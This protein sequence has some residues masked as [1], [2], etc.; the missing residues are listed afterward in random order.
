MAA[1]TAVLDINTERDDRQKV[2]VDGRLYAIRRGDELSILGT[3]SVFTKFG[4]LAG[5]LDLAKPTKV[6]ARAMSE[7]LDEM[8]RMVL[9]APDSVHV[10]L[11]DSQRLQVID[12]FSL[13]LSKTPPAGATRPPTRRQTRSTGARK[14]RG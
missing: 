2:R 4:E 10:K 7:L 3:R 1:D 13:L 9:E 14:S 6:Q 8:C 5:L 11:R 12:V